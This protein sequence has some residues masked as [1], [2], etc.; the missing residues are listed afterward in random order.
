MNLL[1]IFNKLQE[2]LN[3]FKTHYYVHKMQS[4]LFHHSIANVS[5]NYAVLQVDFSEKFSIKFQDE[6]QSA[7]YNQHPI[8]IFTCCVWLSNKKQ[9]FGVLSDCT[10]QDKSLVWLCLQKNFQHLQRTCSNVKDVKI[11]SVGAG[12]Q[13][14]NK[15]TL[16][17]LVYVHDDF[18]LN[19]AWEFMA[20]SHGK[21][22]VDGIGAVLKQKLWSA[23][24]SRKIILKDAKDCHKY[25]ENNINGVKTFLAEENELK[26]IQKK[27][28]ARWKAVTPI[29]NV[30]KMHS[31][32]VSSNNTLQ[33]KTCFQSEPYKKH[34]VLKRLRF[35]DV[36]SDSEEEKI[37]EPSA[38]IRTRGRN[39][40]K[41]SVK[42][43]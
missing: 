43:D 11:F 30:K 34:T 31:F 21:G 40:R 28:Q 5:S 9:C 38:S 29:P 20:T 36:Y 15:F 24:R 26:S 7:Y 6:A 33:I 13:F 42:S 37:S 32:K 1:Q 16:S 25:L 18:K 19:I 17:N 2:K 41:I 35:E 3:A 8:S 10:E 14:K 22:A 27:F 12:S 4:Q 23:I 39:R